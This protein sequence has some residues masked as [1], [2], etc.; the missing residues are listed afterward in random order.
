MHHVDQKSVLA[1]GMTL[2]IL[3]ILEY[4][5]DV[6]GSHATDD[7]S[8]ICPFAICRG[9]SLKCHRQKTFKILL[10]KGTNTLAKLNGVFALDILRAWRL[11]VVS[12]AYS[13]WG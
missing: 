7:S 9:K 8:S 11:R 2:V 5:N 13:Q 12:P 1:L 10:K 4:S 6:T 3:E